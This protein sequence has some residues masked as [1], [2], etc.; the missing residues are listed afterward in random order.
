MVTE[1]LLKSKMTPETP[2]EPDTQKRIE[3]IIRFQGFLNIVLLL[4]LIATLVWFLRIENSVTIH[5]LAEQFDPPVRVTV[6]LHVYSGNRKLATADIVRD[7]IVTIYG[8]VMDYAN[9][10]DILEDFSVYVQKTKIAPKV[11]TGEFIEKIVL[12]PG[13]NAVDVSIRWNGEERYRYT[14]TITY[15]EPPISPSA[16]GTAELLVP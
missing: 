5:A 1:I 15:I 11:K 14:Y 7:P 6:P 8:Q 16:T 9:L 13:K 3:R 2:I 10:Y 4:T 12:K